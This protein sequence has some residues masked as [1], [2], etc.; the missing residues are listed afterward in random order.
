MEKITNENV[1]EFYN[2]KRDFYRHYFTMSEKIKKFENNSTPG[3]FKFIFDEDGNRLWRHFRMDCDNNFNKF[4]TYLTQEQTNI[5]V[6]SIVE[7]EN[8]YYL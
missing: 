6:V 2:K 4:L 7:N 3:V 5:L 8:M 1:F